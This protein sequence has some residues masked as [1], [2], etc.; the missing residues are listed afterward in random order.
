MSEEATGAAPLE[1]DPGQAAPDPAAAGQQ[2]AAPE[3]KT[4]GQVAPSGDGTTPQATKAGDSAQAQVEGGYDPTTMD[5]PGVHKYWQKHYT[6]SQQD[7]S[8]L[9][10]QVQQ[11]QAIQNNP[12][13]HIQQWLQQ[14]GLTAVRQGEQ[15][16][17]GGEEGYDGEGQP[18][19]PVQPKIPPEAMQWALQTTQQVQRM[20][21]TN[22]IRDLNDGFPDWQ[23]Y[24][25]E[26][27]Q[28]LKEYPN[29]ANN[30]DKLYRM[31]VPDHVFEARLAKR[32]QNQTAS[33]AALQST[34]PASAVPE[35]PGAKLD[36][37]LDCWR[38]ACRRNGMKSGI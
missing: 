12:A 35:Q 33:R 37:D 29:L 10:Q 3:T 4:Q 25:A 22:I 1:G 8:D 2:A 19:Q 30:P 16:Q 24:E 32:N 23:D 28:S 13:P 26:I 15:P 9:R 5:G 31:S 17:G 34:P 7:A 27:M 21:M 20:Q 14:Q 18:Y 11:F 36:T 38:E 6:R